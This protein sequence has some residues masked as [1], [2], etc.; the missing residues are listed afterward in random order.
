MPQAQLV[1]PA[2]A[3]DA[4]ETSQA[5]QVPGSEG[6]QQTQTD[7]TPAPTTVPI[8]EYQALKD[9][10][11]EAEKRIGEMRNEVGSYRGVVNDLLEA[12]RQ[13][14]RP[15]EPEPVIEPD[16]LFA[17][18]NEAITSVVERTVAKALEPYQQ[19]LHQ[20]QLSA[21]EADLAQRHPDYVDIAQS[22]DFREWTSQ[23]P[24]R[25]AMLNQALN[26][27]MS[28]AEMLLDAYKAEKG[29][30]AQAP[31][32]PDPGVERARQHAGGTPGAQSAAMPSPTYT[33]DELVDMKLKDPHKYAKA[34]S[35][36]MS[37]KLV[38]R[39]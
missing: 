30:A 34:R 2:P 23:A 16:D 37:G 17:N 31:A 6:Q 24:H 13:E 7:Q 38:V 33:A 35:E 27:D 1:D 22:E 28:A 8:D 15:A 25:G 14:L 20:Q 5:T 21:A 9:R 32:T 26:D 11:G 19:S 39:G 4:E 10:Y 3:P 29:A 18:P 36:I 12:Q